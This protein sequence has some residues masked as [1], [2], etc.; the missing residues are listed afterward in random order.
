MASFNSFLKGLENTD[1][2]R[3]YNHANRVFGSNALEL[4]PRFNFLFHVFFD[5]DPA[6]Q[7]ALTQVGQDQK[8]LGLL[9]KSVDLPRYDID[10]KVLNSYN[11]SNIVQSKIKY[12]PINIVFHD[13]S[14]DIIRNFWYNYYSFYY[15]DSDQPDNSYDYENKYDLNTVDQKLH[16]YTTL[17]DRKR[18]LKSI[19][20]YSMS[21]KRAA[22]YVLINPIITQFQHG[23]HQTRSNNE[24]LEH[25]M[26]VEY[27]TVKYNYL[28]TNA[29]KGFADDNYYD[30]RAS[31]IARP[32]STRSVFGTGGLLASIDAVTQ[33][34]ADG[35]FISARRNIR[36]TQQVFKGTKIKDVALTEVRNL[37]VDSLRGQNSFSRIQVPTVSGT[38]T[39]PQPTAAVAKPATVANGQQGTPA[40]TSPVNRGSAT[41]NGG[42][43]SR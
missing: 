17:N 40:G 33:D 1:S 36:A 32:G 28:P 2:L 18:F 42:T 34:L 25:T 41:S 3:D 31:P 19:R 39:N 16:G 5:L 43:V 27:E 24:L 20:I 15:R 13:D 26:T 29:L 14:A 8:V 6:Q 12:Q 38:G 30:K 35:N 11:R 23:Q 22:E 4:S 7:N 10:T 9:V 37:A 21:R